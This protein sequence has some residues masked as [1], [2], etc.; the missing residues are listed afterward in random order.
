MTGGG[1]A[2]RRGASD[3]LDEVR[4]ALS[5]LAERLSDVAIDALRE[6]VA[7]GETRRPEIERRVTRAR[8]AVERAVG[9]LAGAEA[10][11]AGAGA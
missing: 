7:A 3:E 6:A 4:E 5:A 2:G 9:I 1:P 8:H 10:G 11:D